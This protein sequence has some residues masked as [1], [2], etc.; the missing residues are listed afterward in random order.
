MNA[1]FYRSDEQKTWAETSL[2]ARAEQLGISESKVETSILPVRTFTYAEDY[3]QKYYLTRYAEIRDFLNETYPDG[4]SLGDSAVATRLN[5]YLG[6]GTDRDWEKFR[7]ELPSY[8]LPE[9][10]EEALRKT[11]DSQ[12]T[13]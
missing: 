7:L 9:K 8:G 3:H 11:A 10:L 1:V 13:R 4:K 5:A 12:I 2:I 6:S